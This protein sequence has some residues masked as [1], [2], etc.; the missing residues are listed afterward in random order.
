[1]RIL[2]VWLL[3]IAG[4][5]LAADS[6][7]PRFRGPY[8]SGIT[9]E[10]LSLTAE[11]T[12]LWAKWIG[13][14]NASLIAV[15]GKAYTNARHG[16]SH[17]FCLDVKAG[18]VAYKTKY[19]HQYENQKCQSSFSY[20]DGRLYALS[21]LGKPIVYCFDAKDG[22]VIWRTPLDVLEKGPKHSHAGS[23]LIFGKLIVVNAGYGAALD[24]ASGEVVWQHKGHSGLATPV[25]F[26][27]GTTQGVAI[28]AGDALLLRDIRDGRGIRR[29]HWK[30]HEG[31]N[32]GDPLWLGDRMW[33]NGSYW[34]AGTMIDREGKVLWKQRGAGFANSIAWQ[35]HLLTFVDRDFVCFDRAGEEQW[36]H[37]RVG[38]GAAIVVDGK[39]ILIGEKGKVAIAQVSAESFTPSLSFQAIDGTTWTPPAYHRGKL[40]VRNNGGKIACWQIAK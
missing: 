37:P 8:G 32:A 21:E 11:P 14:G 34:R 26:K 39:L 33:I 4:P 24:K 5:A 15:D 29:F 9:R 3:I 12:Q 1:M 19:P 10:A 18:E 25:A 22:S 6:A 23:P 30:S 17:I 7:W 16:A 27:A 2:T 13:A 35:D 40:L 28:F 20:E 36:R 31:I 38:V